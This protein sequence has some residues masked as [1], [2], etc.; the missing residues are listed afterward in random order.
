M[1]MLLR[2]AIITSSIII[3]TCLSAQAQF[4][5]NVFVAD[6]SIKAYV[7]SGQRPLAWTGGMNNPQ[8]AMAD[9]NND[10]KADMIVYES[11]ASDF[12][13][14]FLNMGTPGNP[15]YVYAPS[16][17]DPFKNLVTDYLKLEDY[18]RDGVPDLITKGL[19][20]FTVYRGRYTGG[21]IQ[22]TLYKEL[23]YNS[24]GGTINCYSQAGDIPG[25][26]DVD[27]DGDLDFFGYNEDGA[28]VYF[29][30]NCQVEH[31]LPNDSIEVCK[32]TNCWGA[33]NQ[34]FIRKFTLGIANGT[35]AF[36]PTINNYGC[37]GCPAHKGTLHQGNAICMLDMEG[38]G[39]IDMLDGN[40][41]FKDIQYLQN[42]R[43]QN[44][45][46]DSMVAQDTTWQRNG[47]QVNMPYWPAA[48]YLDAD[49]D[50][51]KD[52]LIAPHAQS[53]S[54][55]Y[56]CVAFYKNMGSAAA[57][58]FV[59]QNDT[60][61]IDRMLDF[62]SMSYPVM[63]DYNKDGR[64]D[65]FVGSMGYYQPN[66]TFRSTLSYF[67]NTLVG[68]QTR[69]SLVSSDFMNIFSENATGTYPAFG[70]LDNDGKD[71]MVV[72]HT[73]G[74]IFFYKNNAASNTVQPQW[75]APVLLRDTAAAIINVTDNVAPVIYDINKD[76]KPDL[77]LTGE[78]GRVVYFQNTSTLPNDMRLTHIM[79]TLG[80][81]RAASNF[82]SYATM[83]IGRMDNTNKDY[84][85]LGSV[86]GTFRRYH[87]FES[88]NTNIPY[89]LIDTAYSNIQIPA[90]SAA[91][92]ADIDGDG[93]YEMIAG[94]MLGGLFQYKQVL[95]VATNVGVGTVHNTGSCSV[96][97]N[98]ASDAFYVNWDAVFAGKDEVHI[99]LINMTG[100]T[101]AHTTVSG[102]KGVGTIPVSA[103]PAGVYVCVVQ[104]GENIYT[105][106]LM[107]QGK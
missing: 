102:V 47:V 52:L 101:I 66:G 27:G 36:C 22:F 87:G 79:D 45:G 17:A 49:G 8:F 92:V 70:D 12:V 77:L 44:G 68:G 4:Q 83:Y 46:I 64:P 5:G 85:L 7:G 65:L 105:Q 3:L 2:S 103:Y 67:Q 43:A 107:I 98:P 100:Q 32:P 42:G 19:G 88:G 11:W 63:Y 20:G 60:F 73:D 38:D 94:N 41:S 97:P 40:I 53:V 6:T 24:P 37:K 18:N 56:K 54:E 39:D 80:G 50:G 21:S 89:Q 31:G 9:M 90:R 62:G 106:R 34:G 99:R 84:V 95:N 96:Y 55:N 16:F 71:D 25:V 86:G 69:F 13:R 23:R 59:Y 93:K 72:G 30:K 51:K 10:G 35:L 82:Y 81:M 1:A 28:I 15:N 76:G 61:M 104:A 14:V 26:I 78:I 33:M 48:F 75:Q 91:T 74:T 57:P 29:F 58:N